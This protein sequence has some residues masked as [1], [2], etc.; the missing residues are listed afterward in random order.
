LA[1]SGLDSIL[2]TKASPERCG[3]LYVYDAFPVASFSLAATLSSKVLHTESY[4][5]SKRQSDAL[6]SVRCEQSVGSVAASE[7]IRNN[8]VGLSQN[9]TSGAAAQTAIAATLLA[10]IQQDCG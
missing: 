6:R 8:T 1:F 7:A 10:T 5:T 3:V 2:A 4:S 9:E